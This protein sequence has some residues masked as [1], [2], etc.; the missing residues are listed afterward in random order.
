[1]VRKTKDWDAGVRGSEGKVVM[2]KSTGD[3][4]MLG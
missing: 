4:V 2:N 1:M 3:V